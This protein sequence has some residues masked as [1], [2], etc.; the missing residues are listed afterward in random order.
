[1][2]LKSL[3]KTYQTR[4]RKEFIDYDYIKDLSEDEKKLLAQFTDEY[5]GGAVHKTKSRIRKDGTT[6]YGSGKIRSGHLH[7]TDELAKDC[8]DRNNRQ[9][10]DVLGITKA[11][12]LVKEL[13]QELADKDGWYITNAEL[14]EEALLSNI[15]KNETE[16]AYLSREE[17]EAVR[18]S[19]TPEM[20]VFYLALYDLE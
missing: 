5:Y 6:V 7:N 9:N 16:E 10:N 17:F 19:L 1:M 18:D 20:L 15:E 3:D 14:T 4:S 2:R 11:N 12:H 13:T 8:Y